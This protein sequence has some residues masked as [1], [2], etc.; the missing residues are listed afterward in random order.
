M[1]RTCRSDHG[2]S[3]W[4]SAS[5]QRAWV[6][7]VR[8]Q[9]RMNYEINR[10]LQRDSGL[11]LADYHVLNA[12]NHIPD[13]KPQVTDLAAFIGWERSRLSHQLRRLCDRGLA[14]RVQSEDDRRATD[15]VLT[16]KGRSAIVS[17]APGHTALVRRLFFDAFPD[18]LVSPFATALENVEAALNLDSSL[19][20]FPPGCGSPT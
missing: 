9:L 6:A 11:S 19:P 7:F 16:E 17:A 15:A 18:E 3:L 5:Q 20:P 13:R 4:L 2:D 12:L 1:P 8:V 14:K 10:Q